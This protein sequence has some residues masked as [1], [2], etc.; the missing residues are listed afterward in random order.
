MTS[1]RISNGSSNSTAKPTQATT[2]S[3]STP[4]STTK[5]L[6]QNL[7]H[8]LNSFE[9]AIKLQE[10]LRSIETAI[11]NLE[12]DNPAEVIAAVEQIEVYLRDEE[13]F[14]TK[15]TDLLNYAFRLEAEAAARQAEADRLIKLVKPGI[16][17]AKR[18]KSMVISFVRILFQPETKFELPFHSIRSRMG[19]PTVDI[20][21]HICDIDS[22]PDEYK[23]ISVRPNK[24][25]LKKAIQEKDL[26]IDGVQLLQ[27][28]DWWIK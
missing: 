8:R 4:V 19:N 3:P 28:R 10:S 25:A 22:L 26:Q 16:N 18:I 7:K 15:A 1:K 9:L 21:E 14:K 6:S 5:G 11:E 23:T 17:R 20:D 12:S 27:K 13:N 2:A 24:T